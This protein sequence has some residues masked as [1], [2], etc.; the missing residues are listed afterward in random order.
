MLDYDSTMRIGQISYQDVLDRLK[1]VGL[2]AM[3]T[4][5]GGCAPP[6]R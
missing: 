4:Q 2:P 6:W 3:F 5:T 1:A